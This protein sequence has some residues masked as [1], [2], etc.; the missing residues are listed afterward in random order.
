MF[1][2]CNHAYTLD[3]FDRQSSAESL[4]DR[5]GA[6]AL[7]VCNDTLAIHFQ[8]NLLYVLLPPLGLR[9]KGPTV[10]PRWML[11]PLP[12]NSSPIATPRR[13]IRSLS[14]VAPTVIW[15]QDQSNSL[16]QCQDSSIPLAEKLCCGLCSCAQVSVKLA[17]L[18][19]GINSPNAKR[20]ILQTE[21]RDPDSQCTASVANTSAHENA[22]ARGE[23][24]L[25]SKGHISNK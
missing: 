5:I 7:P 13:R 8:R 22:S 19:Y 6:K 17:I 1:D 24:R 15:S 12:R 18:I 20:A 21:L 11:T 14:H 4:N 3:S 2:G 25:L 10:G 16:V 23:I 9:P